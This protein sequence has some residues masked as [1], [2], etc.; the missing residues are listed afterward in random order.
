MAQFVRVPAERVPPESLDALLEE[1]TSRDGTDYG[2]QETPL[3]ERVAELRTGLRQGSVALLYD[4]D[5]ETW[6][7]LPEEEARLLVTPNDD[8]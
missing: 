4:G 3:S 6:D 7:L 1:Y 8:E 2:E 5:S